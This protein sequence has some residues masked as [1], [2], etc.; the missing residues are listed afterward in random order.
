MTAAVSDY[1]PAGV[2]R[3]TKRETVE[4][5][6]GGSQETWT[7]EN[8]QADKV[9]SSHGTIAVLGE[10][11]E[12]L[13]DLFRGGWG[14]KGLLVKFK[15]EVGISEEELVKVAETQSRV[16]SGA[17]FIVA[18]TLAMVGGEQAGAYVIGK[19]SCERVAR[20]EL[21]GKLCSDRP[22]RGKVPKS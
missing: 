10:A 22:K 16:A 14:Y 18:N 4:S 7:V 11:T 19:G 17:D 3:V 15:L 1:R 12:K 21:A 13:V 8:V 2:Y 6:K 9:K 5:E 20:A